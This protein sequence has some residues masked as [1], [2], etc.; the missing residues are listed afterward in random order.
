MHANAKFWDKVAEKYSRRPVSD[1]D[2]YAQT[3]ERTRSWL[4]ETDR[5]LEIGC[6]TG[7][8]ALVLAPSVA[9]LTATDISAEMIRI[10]R[11]KAQTDGP[12][13]LDFRVTAFPEGIGTPEP[14]DVVM[15]FNLLHLVPDVDGTLAQVHAAL[16]PGGLF[17]S[18]TGC[19]GGKRLL[20]AM[21]K[22]M[23]L[24]GKAPMVHAF[25]TEEIE[26]RIARAGFEI[27][28][29]GSYPDRSPP[30]RFV[31]ARKL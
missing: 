30:S 10:A 26:A 6:G 23:Q 20:L 4:N 14:L 16:K 27:V 3:L 31:V 18:K 24:V 21:I 28:E 12:A 15:A 17:I 25:T 2:A 1:P 19:V 22:V 11:R 5:A 9:H 29:T 13:N 7:S 8:T